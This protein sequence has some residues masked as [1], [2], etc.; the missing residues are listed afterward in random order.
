MACF[1]LEK[2]MVII[3]S[4]S[5]QKAIEHVETVDYELLSNFHSG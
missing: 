3:R 5:V 2:R 4:L 1:V